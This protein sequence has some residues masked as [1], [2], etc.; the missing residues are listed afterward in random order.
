MGHAGLVLELLPKPKTKKGS[1]DVEAEGSDPRPGHP[2][3]GK[4]LEQKMLD[5][6][7]KRGKTL[8]AWAREKGLSQDA[9]DATELP[10]DTKDC[11]PT[12]A[13]HRRDQQQ[14]YLILY[15]E[16]LLYSTGIAISNLVKFADQKVED[17]TMS[18]KRLIWPGNRRLKKWILSIGRED[19]SV[20]T[21]SPDSMEAGT[22]TVYMGSGFNPK[23]DP[24]H[25]P[26]VT[27]WQ[28]FGN[29]IRTIPRFLGSA[30]SAFG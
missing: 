6:Y 17:G 4:Y 15:L 5:F 18:K 23:K 14:L 29:G 22:N 8:I 16:H 11:T 7:S 9:F 28:K 21:E 2:D 19:T 3:F 12:D 13:Q 10:T 24:E 1:N 20:D 30:E 27:A 25:L 26:A